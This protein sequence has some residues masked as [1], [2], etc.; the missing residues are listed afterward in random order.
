ML[1]SPQ[2]MNL[3]IQPVLVYCQLYVSFFIENAWVFGW[4]NSLAYLDQLKKIVFT[5]FTVSVNVK[6]FEGNF[7]EL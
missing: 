7:L 2:F 6:D 5:D 4:L 3:L 1:L